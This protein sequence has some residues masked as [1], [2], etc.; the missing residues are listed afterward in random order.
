M[1]EDPYQ[2][3]VDAAFADDGCAEFE[4]TLSETA[5]TG[6]LID[7]HIHIA[8]IPDGPHMDDHVHDVNQPPTMGLNITIPDYVCM[9]ETEETKKILPA[10]QNLKKLKL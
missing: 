8:S 10:V 4:R 1:Y 9:M 3:R 5:Y 7:T 6:E 2:E